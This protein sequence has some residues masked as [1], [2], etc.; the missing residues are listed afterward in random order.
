M[1]GYPTRLTLF[2]VTLLSV[3]TACTYDETLGRDRAPLQRG[4]LEARW[5]VT[6]GGVCTSAEQ[7]ARDP[8]GDVLVGG[9]GQ[10][11][12]APIAFIAKLGGLDGAALWSVVVPAMRLQTMAV[13]PDGS[14]YAMTQTTGATTML[15]LRPSG[16]IE[17]RHEMTGW[18]DVT[19]TLAVAATGELYVG[20]GFGHT[21]QFLDGLVSVSPTESGASSDAVGDAFI[22]KLDANGSVLWG[23]TFAGPGAQGIGALAVTEDGVIA[24]ANTYGGAASFG[25]M[26][27]QPT[28]GN[29]AAIV[30]FDENGTFEWSRALAVA[31]DESIGDVGLTLDGLD[32]PMGTGARWMS[33]AGDA[34]LVTWTSTSDHYLALHETAQPWLIG[35]PA[36]ASNGMIV[37]GVSSDSPTRADV[38]VL[39][40]DGSMLGGGSY[41]MAGAPQVDQGFSLHAFSA[42]EHQVIA[43]G[44]LSYAVDFGTGLVWSHSASA[45]PDGSPLSGGADAVVVDLE[46]VVN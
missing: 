35:R 3:A 2:S 6:L 38:R 10:D 20:G 24:T 8:N 13:S 41:Q 16:S 28:G 4:H 26:P 18:N 7:L 34:Q 29:A 25:G 21:I 22:A 11:G 43:A 31:A 27:L 37:G 32:R 23:K 1:S 33:D 46:W 40:L 15:K 17:W 39:D 44:T 45:R 42:T 30:K 19:P 12:E 9:S 5:A 14:T 36:I